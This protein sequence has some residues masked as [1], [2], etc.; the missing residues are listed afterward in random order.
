MELNAAVSQTVEEV[1]ADASRLLGLPVSNFIKHI[2]P[3]PIVQ[4]KAVRT[5]QGFKH[6]WVGSPK[7]LYSLDVTLPNGQVRTLHFSMGVLHSRTRF[8]LVW[9]DRTSNFI[10]VVSRKEWRLM[11]YKMLPL[12]VER[13]VEQNPK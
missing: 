11:V 2:W 4:Y 13:Y 1:F 3:T 6:K 9:A 7:I 12:A 5:A 8:E 10:D